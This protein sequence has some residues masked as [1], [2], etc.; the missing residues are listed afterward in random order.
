MQCTVFDIEATDLGGN[1]GRLLCCSFLDLGEKAKVETYR[2][3]HKPWRGRKL[4]DDAK[5]AVAI[6]DRL[7]EA[8]IIIGWNS[9]LYDVP[10][11]NA[12]LVAAGERPVRV[13]EKYGSHHLDLMYYAGG[14]SMR[15]PGRR[16]DTVAKF[17]HCDNQKTPL[18]PEVWAEAATGDKEAMAE[19]VAHCEADIKV[20]REVFKH[21]APFVKKIQFNLGDVWTFIEQI[22]SRR[23]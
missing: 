6:R 2:R 14:Q 7:E 5:L 18:T 8:D 19:V 13:G 22:D 16:L 17:F 21:L 11:I 4:T 12:R 15:L 10:F 23:R 1:F 9:I 3:D 20:T